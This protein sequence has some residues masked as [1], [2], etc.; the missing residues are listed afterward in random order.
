MRSVDVASPHEFVDRQERDFPYLFGEARDLKY[1]TDVSVPE[2]LNELQIA[3][4][5]ASALDL[6]LI[7]L[8]HTSD[9]EIRIEAAAVLDGLLVRNNVTDYLKNIFYARPLPPD[10][11]IEASLQGC[12]RAKANGAASFFH[13]LSILQGTILE[14]RQGWEAISD[15]VFGNREN[16]EEF[17]RLAVHA[18]L[19]RDFVI[20]RAR[21]TPLDRFLDQALSI[22]EIRDCPKH[23][24]IL[25]QWIAA[26]GNR[27]ENSTSVR[28]LLELSIHQP[29]PSLDPEFDPPRSGG[30]EPLGLPVPPLANQELLHLM[31]LGDGYTPAEIAERFQV[32][33]KVVLREVALMRRNVKE[34]L[35]HRISLD[36]QHLR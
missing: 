34:K 8:D 10:T 4:D 31:M 20:T 26:T 21:G 7:C 25:N 18:G 13:N 3:Y 1:L 12:Q 35:R 36:L 5:C 28:R 33:I 9:A 19:F 32:S 15:E 30:Y 27:F 6:A 2:A 17:Q 16:R 14:T 22:S 24:V 29:P 23:S 11:N